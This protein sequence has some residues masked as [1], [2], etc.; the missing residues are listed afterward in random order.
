MSKKI[1]YPRN[2]ETG[3]PSQEDL[4]K[5]TDEVPEYT[6]IA[7]SDYLEKTK[8]VWKKAKEE[9]NTW[10]YKFEIHDYSVFDMEL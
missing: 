1:K 8:E 6:Y 5:I 2:R 9:I 4:L 7:I 3:N 10:P